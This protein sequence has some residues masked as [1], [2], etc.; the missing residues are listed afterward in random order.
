MQ[1]SSGIAIVS[2]QFFVFEYY[3]VAYVFS[4]NLIFEI[5]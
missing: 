3:S 5:V 4:I 2:K 1:F